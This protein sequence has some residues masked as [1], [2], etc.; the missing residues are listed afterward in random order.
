M[1]KFD[2]LQKHLQL[3]DKQLEDKVSALKEQIDQ[4]RARQPK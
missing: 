3:V 4:V 2:E 1:S